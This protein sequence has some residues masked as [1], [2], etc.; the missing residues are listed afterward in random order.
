MFQRSKYRQR[1]R[2]WFFMHVPK[3][4]GTTFDAHIQNTFGAH[5]IWPSCEPA[6]EP[7][8]VHALYCD[9][10]SLATMSAE[11]RTRTRLFRGH[12]PL[13]AVELLGPGVLTMTLLRDPVERTI[14]WLDHCRRNNPEHHDLTLE[15]VYE[16]AWFTPRYATTRRRSCSR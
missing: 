11:S 8:R 1:V 10:D 9:V 14:S 15:H 3:T 6:N 12:F 5:Q 16:D 13:S 4:G 7:V 2:R